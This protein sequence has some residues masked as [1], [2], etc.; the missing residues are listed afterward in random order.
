MIEVTYEPAAAGGLQ[1]FLFFVSIAWAAVT[2]GERPPG[3][4]D[5]AAPTLEEFEVP[6]AEDGAPAK[7]LFGTCHDRKP[8]V[9][10]W[11]DLSAEAIRRNVGG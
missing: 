1:V 9:G 2:R 5:A 4:Q 10:W 3:P 6:G 8:Q 7:V 11:G